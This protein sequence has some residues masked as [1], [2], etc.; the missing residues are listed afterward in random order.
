MEDR[1]V[2]IDKKEETISRFALLRECVEDAGVSADDDC[3]QNGTPISNEINSRDYERQAHNPACASLSMAQGVDRTVM[4]P[5]G[6]DDLPWQTAF[7]RRQ[8][9][10]W[11]KTQGKEAAYR[12]DDNIPASVSRDPVQQHVASGLILKVTE[13]RESASSKAARARLGSKLAGEVQA[14][15][16]LHDK[17]S[18]YQMGLSLRPEQT[19]P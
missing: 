17:S 13:A 14:R 3:D 10:Q 6:K 19:S 11:V 8:S 1:G 18:R 2:I 9:N 12:G 4:A 15:Q 5:P 16:R 7:E